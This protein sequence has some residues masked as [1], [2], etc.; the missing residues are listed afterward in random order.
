MKGHGQLSRNE[1]FRTCGDFHYLVFWTKN[2]NF[3][4]FPFIRNV[5]E[6]LGPDGG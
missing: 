5:K 4:H 1:R 2:E 3:E 6:D